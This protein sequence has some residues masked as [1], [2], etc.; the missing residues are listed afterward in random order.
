MRGDGN[1]TRGFGSLRIMSMSSLALPTTSDVFFFW[2][3][4]MSTAHTN[5]GPTGSPSSKETCVYSHSS[6]SFLLALIEIP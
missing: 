6:A 2:L 3:K 4:H 5:P 1:L